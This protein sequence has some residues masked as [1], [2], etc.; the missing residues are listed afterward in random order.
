[1]QDITFRREFAT[2]CGMTQAEIE[3]DFA[4]EIEAMALQHNVTRE[5]LLERIR[6]NYN[7]FRFAAGAE[8]VYNPF[9]TVNLFGSGMFDNY[10]ADSGTPS[11]LAKLMKTQNVELADVERKWLPKSTVDS[12][13]PDRLTLLP[14]LLQT[15]Y[16]TITDSRDSGLLDGLE[17][18]VDFPNIEVRRSFVDS[19]V[20]V[21]TIQDRSEYGVRA[22]DMGQFLA[23]GQLDKFLTAMK[24]V[25]TAIPYQLDDATERRYHGLFHAMSVLACNP[26]ALVLSEVPNAIGRSDRVIDLPDV[27]WI[28]EFKRDTDTA[29][30]LA[31]IEVKEYAHQWEGRLRVDG[32]PK[33]VKKVAVNFG[34]VDRNIVGW[35][36]LASV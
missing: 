29:E 1:L 26:P 31:Q 8:G 6:K 27:C 20:Q 21:H 9:S 5:F 12:L 10:W 24:K 35:E 3:R 34:T 14:L 17:Y 36:V 32:S 18:F 13:N 11:F 4:P 16:L 30:A 22:R 15:G 19:L 25:Y 2:L 28:F 7:G 23:V 33:P